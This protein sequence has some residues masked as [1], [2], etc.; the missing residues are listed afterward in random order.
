MATENTE[1]I[2][3]EYK[4]RA[5]SPINVGGGGGGFLQTFMAEKS[6]VTVKAV[7]E[8][9]DML[10]SSDFVGQGGNYVSATY[11]RYNDVSGD[12]FNGREVEKPEYIDEDDLKDL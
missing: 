8:G 5:G 4:L 11:N 12:K 2:G 9:N 7:V 6:K 10:N 1:Y 3:Y